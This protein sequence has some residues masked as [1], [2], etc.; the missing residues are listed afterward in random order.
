VSQ[1]R[2]DPTGGAA[3]P[4]TRANSRISILAMQARSI[5]AGQSARPDLGDFSVGGALGEVVWVGLEAGV[6]CPEVPGDV[7]A[8]SHCLATVAWQRDGAS[9]AFDA[10]VKPIQCE[11][12]SQSA[13][14]AV[15][16]DG[17]SAIRE[18]ASVPDRNML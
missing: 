5:V 2:A 13:L 1:I 11:A 18:T 9:V 6:R 12:T 4:S 16:G 17:R 8:R 7:F 15:T 14:A 10:G 3:S